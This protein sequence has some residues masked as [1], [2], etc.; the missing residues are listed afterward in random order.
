[1]NQENRIEALSFGTLVGLFPG[2]LYFFPHWM[3][4]PSEIQLYDTYCV[5]SPHA[6]FLLMAAMLLL[7]VYGIKEAFY[8]YNRPFQNFLFLI[9][10]AVTEWFLFQIVVPDF[11]NSSNYALKFL[12]YFHC[13]LQGSGLFLAY[14]IGKNLK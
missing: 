8:K 4:F 11:V 5:F 2:V 6:F 13:F 1:M 7:I 12:L 14:K 10:L 9:I 3:P